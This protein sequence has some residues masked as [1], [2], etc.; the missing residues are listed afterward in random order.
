MSKPYIEI[1]NVSEICKALGLPKSQAARVEI[2][3]DLVIAIFTKIKAKKLT[4]EKAAELAGVGR[5]VITAVVNGSIGK[6]S[7]DRLIDIADGLGL[8]IA[9][10]VA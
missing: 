2:R 7:T 4:H 5:T 6:I 10:K 9:I 3:R 1:K 8:D